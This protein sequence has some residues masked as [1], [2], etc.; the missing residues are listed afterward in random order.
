L[1]N[2]EFKESCDL[3]RRGVETE[4]INVTPRAIRRWRGWN[5]RLLQA[6]MD[7]VAAA[8][9]RKTVRS[10]W[11]GQQSSW[12]LPATRRYQSSRNPPGAPLVQPL[13]DSDWLVELARWPVPAGS[14]GILKAFEQFF[15]RIS[16]GGETVY[17]TS[18]H[19]GNPYPTYP[20][21]VGVRWYLR[22]SPIAEVAGPWRNESGASAIPE[23]L[24]GI[25]YDDLPWTEDLW[26]PAASSSSANIHLP[27]PGNYFLRVISIVSAS[28]SQTQARIAAKVAGT[29]QT[30]LSRDTQFMLRTS[31]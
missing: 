12:Q 5:T 23:Y 30:E 29:I 17:T 24:P 19:W 13:S 11:L 10:P 8:W 21:S 20:D 26:Y 4:V 28:E 2:P 18:Q 31:W 25:P 1:T 22:L 15:S 14:V 6:T 7:N 3:V 27:I 16:L 9:Q